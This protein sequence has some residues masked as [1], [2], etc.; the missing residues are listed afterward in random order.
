MEKQKSLQ[1]ASA[2]HGPLQ[3]L[4]NAPH[5]TA[6]RR[7]ADHPIITMGYHSVFAVEGSIVKRTLVDRRTNNKH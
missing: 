1:D 7:E 6:G 5:K 2:V 4:L 3:T